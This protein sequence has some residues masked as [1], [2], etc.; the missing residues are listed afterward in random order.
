MANNPFHLSLDG[1]QKRFSGTK[2]FL[3]FHHGPFGSD[4]RGMSSL[5]R[6]NS[7]MLEDPTSS[8][9]SEEGLEQ[10]LEGAN[11]IGQAAVVGSQQPEDCHAESSRAEPLLSSAPAHPQR[12]QRIFVDART[13]VMPPGAAAA[14]YTMQL[15]QPHE[16]LSAALS[17]LERQPSSGLGDGRALGS[18]V[19]AGMGRRAGGGPDEGS[20]G[21]SRSVRAAA[22]SIC[23]HFPGG[24]TPAL[25]IVSPPP[26]PSSQH[27]QPTS[28]TRS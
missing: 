10:S 24:S 23:P 20:D 9:E 5:D 21:P 4:L 27:Q 2:C 6:E 7:R 19:S 26:A 22:S 25:P 18:Q 12:P 17:P 16:T 1:A 11:D 13:A 15:M 14:A 28:H 8:S 3:S